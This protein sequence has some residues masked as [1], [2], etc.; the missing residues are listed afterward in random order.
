MAAENA[1]WISSREDGVQ[2]HVQA[3]SSGNPRA[4]VPVHQPTPITTPH[5]GPDHPNPN[6]STSSQPAAPHHQQ[7]HLEQANRQWPLK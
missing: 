7:R 5:P 3:A 6:T 2:L 4:Q 1:D